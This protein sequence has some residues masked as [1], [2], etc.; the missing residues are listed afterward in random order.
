VQDIHVCMDIY[1]LALGCVYGVVH[2]ELRT[3][4]VSIF[5]HTCAYSLKCNEINDEGAQHIAAALAQNSSL[6]TLR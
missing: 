1:D 6:Q 4:A 2:R 5:T 3:C